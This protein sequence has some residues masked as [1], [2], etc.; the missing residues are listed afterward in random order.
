MD[1]HYILRYY[2]CCYVDVLA[3]VLTGSVTGVAV[4]LELAVVDVEPDPLP[5]FCT[6]AC[7]TWP[8]ALKTMSTSEPSA[9]YENVF[10]IRPL[11][12]CWMSPTWVM[13]VGWR[14][15]RAVGDKVSKV[16]GRAYFVGSCR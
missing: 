11:P 13:S 15:S 12:S 2:A 10:W 9:S 7:T 4:A 1:Y 5:P 14:V 6:V 3:A 8:A 16:R